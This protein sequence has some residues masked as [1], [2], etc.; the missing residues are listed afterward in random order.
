MQMWMGLILEP[1]CLPSFF[2][3]MPQLIENGYLYI[4]QPPLYKAKKGK[5]EN[6]LKDEKLL[7][8][9]FD[10]TGNRKTC[11]NITET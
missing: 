11:N 4:A 6:Y 7:F 5:K 8:P 3:Q 9:V 1:C 10:G 2:R